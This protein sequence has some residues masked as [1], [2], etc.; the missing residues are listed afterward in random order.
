MKKSGKRLTSHGVPP[1]KARAVIYLFAASGQATA[2]ADTCPAIVVLRYAGRPMLGMGFGTK[3]PA[4]IDL[5]KAI[6]SVPDLKV[7]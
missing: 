2:F 3:S 5:S 7:L 6:N 4:R 1:C